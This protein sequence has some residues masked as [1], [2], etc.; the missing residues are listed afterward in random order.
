MQSKY[1]VGGAVALVLLGGVFFAKSKLFSPTSTAVVP[2]PTPESVA[3]LPP[4]KQPK[5]SLSFS[6]DGH[7]VTVNI[8]DINAA[9]LEYNLIYDA[10][11]KNTQI[12][13][14]VSG[15]S[16]LNGANTYSYKQLLGSESSGHFTY[17]SNIKNATMELTLRN[18][19]GYSVFNTTYSYLVSPGK[20][21]DLKVAP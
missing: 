16:K 1:L 21:I 7:Y 20:T 2:T 13:T 10:T 4:D 19:A 17:H 14:G 9:Q 3:Q 18:A 6:G 12:N 11:V 5:V 15:S 8:T